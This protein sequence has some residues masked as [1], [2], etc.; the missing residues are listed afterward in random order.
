MTWEDIIEKNIKDR[1]G[2]RLSTA[3]NTPKT[4]EIRI[5]LKTL[6]K[7]L[8]DAID[9]ASNNTQLE[10]FES[11]LPQ[12]EQIIRTIKTQ[13]SKQIDQSTAEIRSRQTR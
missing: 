9:A 6:R 8:I 4:K 1:M 10:L 12:L 3:N 7:E 5:K 2:A 11:V 13:T